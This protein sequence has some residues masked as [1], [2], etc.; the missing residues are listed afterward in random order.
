M[1]PLTTIPHVFVTKGFPAASSM[2]NL[3]DLIS[4]LD[5]MHFSSILSCTKEIK[6]V[7]KSVSV[8]LSI[9]VG[10]CMLTDIIF[11]S[12]IVKVIWLLEFLFRHRSR[13]C[14]FAG[15]SIVVMGV[16]VLVMTLWML[17]A[18]ISVV[19]VVMLLICVSVTIILFEM[20]MIFTIS[21]LM[22]MFLVS[23]SM[24]MMMIF[25]MIS[26]VMGFMVRLMFL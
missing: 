22:V 3:L 16:L 25:L 21:L 7:L 11:K 14:V 4:F 17:V 5:F 26:I 20:N 1:R 23:S 9:L 6:S 10:T 2:R 15:S 18:F 8:T 19:Y 12:L 24:L 13:R